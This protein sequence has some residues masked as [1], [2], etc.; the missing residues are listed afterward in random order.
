[1]TPERLNEILSRFSQSRIA[2]IGDFFL[3]KYLEIDPALAEKSVETG[4][5]AH[6]V[7]EIRRFPGAAGTVVNNLAELQAGK[8]HAIG[9]TGDDG[10]AYDLRSEL[11]KRNCKTEGLLRFESMMTPTYLKPRDQGNPDLAGEHERYDT[12]NRNEI[13][14]SIGEAV[15][16]K[17]DVILPNVDAVIVAD[18]VEED[19]CG[20]ITSVVRDK[21]AERSLEFPDVV[22]WADSRT[23][24]HDF[25]NMIIKANQFEAVQH[26]SPVPG[27]EIGIEE[28]KNILP[29]LKKKINA[30]ICITRGEYGILVSDPEFTAVPGIKLDCPVDPTGAG[31]SVTAGMVLA[32]T[33][34]ATLPEAGLIGMLVASITVQQL[35]TTGTATPEQVRKQ[36]L[37]WQEQNPEAISLFE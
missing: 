14:T 6:Q 27:E 24:I 37:L 1:M 34:G 23:H 32:L 28:V 5:T 29:E 21:L 19:N 3:D 8:L 12:K 36:L 25:R 2:V 35:A 11:N 9:A 15:L 16:E 31:D 13:E 33:S 10:E 7:A 26:E 17:L 30:P 4:K 18:Q 22:F 20:V